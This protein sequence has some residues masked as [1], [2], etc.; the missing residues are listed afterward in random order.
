VRNPAT[1]KITD[2]FVLAVVLLIASPL[3]AHHGNAAFDNA[4]LLTVKGTVTEWIWANPHCFLKFDA[5]DE[6]NNVVHWVAELNNPPEMARR[7]WTRETLKTGDDLS[8]FLIPAKNGRPIGRVQ[9]V[10]LPNGQVLMAMEGLGN[11][12]R[13]EEPKPSDEPK[14]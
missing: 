4:K 13:P 8:I 14:Q 11:P 1:N 9:K 3:L 12:A 10:V 7:G 6:S 2:V 5:K